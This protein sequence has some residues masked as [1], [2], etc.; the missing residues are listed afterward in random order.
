MYTYGDTTSLLRAAPS[1][2]PMQHTAARSCL[3]DAIVHVLYPAILAQQQGDTRGPHP[4]WQHP[5]S[6][7]QALGTQS[8]GNR[9]PERWACNTAVLGEARQLCEPQPHEQALLPLPSFIHSA[10]LK[11]S[12]LSRT[13]SPWRC[14][15]RGTSCSSSSD[16]LSPKP[17]T[18]LRSSLRSFWAGVRTLAALEGMGLCGWD[19]DK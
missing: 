8:G 13:R 3:P 19:V 16:Q 11:L 15:E 7:G 18:I 10:A 2:E 9:L 1:P 17:S 4:S 12:S 6:P 5:S 14:H